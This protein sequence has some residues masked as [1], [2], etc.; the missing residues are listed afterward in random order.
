MCEQFNEKNLSE[1]PM[2]N[3]YPPSSLQSRNEQEKNSQCRGYI[4]LHSIKL[5]RILLSLPNNTGVWRGNAQNKTKQ[6]IVYHIIFSPEISE[7]R[8]DF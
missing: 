8:V 2:I 1:I 4:Y 6:A 7:K 5:L 3:W